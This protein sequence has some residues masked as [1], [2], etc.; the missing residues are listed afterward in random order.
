MRVMNI[1]INSMKARHPKQINNIIQFFFCQTANKFK[2]FTNPRLKRI[3]EHDTKRP[4]ED[5]DD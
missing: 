4:K 5:E 2:T 3:K 1:Q